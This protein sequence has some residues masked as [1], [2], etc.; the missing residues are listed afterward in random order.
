MLGRR[1]SSPI[2]LKKR[3]A[4]E[5]RLE[6]RSKRRRR[7]DQ[8]CSYGARIV[9]VT[10]ETRRSVV[11]WTRS[12]L[13]SYYS[14][15]TLGFPR[16]GMSPPTAPPS[17]DSSYVFTGTPLPTRCPDYKPCCHAG[18]TG[19]LSSATKAHHEALMYYSTS[20]AAQGGRAGH[21]GYVPLVRVRCRE[22]IHLLVVPLLNGK[23]PDHRFAEH[24]LF[25]Y[26]P[27]TVLS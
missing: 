15:P 22:H 8:G 6:M 1:A 17:P 5:K 21:C 10:L 23:L 18:A 19:L 9:D 16:L 26:C 7:P 12:K 2:R 24:M 13:S 3:M 14:L 20:T 27:V 11:A 25:G 4:L